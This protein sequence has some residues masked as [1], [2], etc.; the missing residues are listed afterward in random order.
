MEK[1]A[2]L[3]RLKA[4]VK[5]LEGIRGRHTELVSVYV[6]AGYNINKVAEQ[7]G[8]ARS[9]HRLVPIC[10][11]KKEQQEQQQQQ[12]TSSPSQHLTHTPPPHIG[13]PSNL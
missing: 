13:E 2:E 8:H 12:G 4:V 9:T 10:P 5:E 7:G 6:P 1:Q 3:K 11:D